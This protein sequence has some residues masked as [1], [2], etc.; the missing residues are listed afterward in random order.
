MSN[1]S[2]QLSTFDYVIVGS[3]SAGSLVA[4]RLSEDPN[5]NVLVIEAGGPANDFWLRL[6]VGYFKSIYNKRFSHLYKTE[7]SDTIAGRQMDAP[8]G[9]VVGGS[10]SI[11]GLIFIRGQHDDFDDWSKQGAE[12]WS[13]ADVLPHFRR[14]EHFEG[15]ASQYRGQHGGLNVSQLRNQNVACDDW[16]KAAFG[17]GL[18]RN[19]DFNGASSFGVGEYQLTIKGHWRES[20][21]TAF[22]GP[23]LERPNLTL[24]TRTQVTRVVIEYGRATGVEIVHNGERKIIDAAAEVI[25]SAG[26][27]QSPQL[28]QLSGIGPASL[29][30]KHGIKV[31]QDAPEVGENLQDHLQMRTIV[32]L[33]NGR[34]SLNNQIRNP[35]KLA[36]MGMD[37]FFAGKGPLTVGAGQVGGATCTKYAT[38]E[39]PDLQLFVM[40]LSVDKPGTP[41]HCYPG[42][43]TSFWQCHPESRGHIRQHKCTDLYDR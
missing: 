42:F 31:V 1:K 38:G 3:G 10:S 33:S 11:N 9:R 18:P 16:L 4:T 25:L 23:A 26:A 37:W 34:D 30:Q 12:G 27:V 41:L 2:D 15:P 13:Y 14:F 8:R 29:L 22:L 32:E 20:A 21:H 24:M 39:R 43:T 5:C 40:P 7:A 36:K 28:L 6:P 35:F 19:E 17:T